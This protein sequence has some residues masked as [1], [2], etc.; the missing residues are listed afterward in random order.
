M[1]VRFT[2]PGRCQSWAGAGG[3]WLASPRPG[4]G[5]WDRAEAGMFGCVWRAEPWA[6]QEPSAASVAP[7]GKWGPEQTCSGRGHLCVR[8]FRKL[9]THMHGDMSVWSPGR[10]TL[11]AASTGPGVC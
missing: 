11:G 8:V 9:G 6:W 1:G 5:G 10:V 7:P 4:L 2:G 3:R